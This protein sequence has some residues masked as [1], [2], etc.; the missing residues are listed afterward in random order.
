MAGSKE[1]TSSRHF[2]D[3]PVRNLGLLCRSELLQEWTT[4]FYWSLGSTK[5]VRLESKT[6]DILKI[7]NEIHLA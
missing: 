3:T 2:D 6:L 5:L 4:I 7:F 1:I